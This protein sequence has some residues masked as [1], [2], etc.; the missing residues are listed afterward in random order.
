MSKDYYEILGVDEEATTEQIKRAYRRK[1]MKVHPDVAQGEDAAEKFKELSEAYEVLSDS[2][3]RAIYD[4]GGDPL[5]R[6]G[7]G[8]AG[9]FGGTGFGGFDFSTIMD[10]MFG[11]QGAGG[12]GG[13]LVWVVFIP[14]P[15]C[16]PCWVVGGPPPARDPVLS[17][18]RMRWS[19]QGW[20][21]MR[22]FLDA[23]NPSGSTRQWCARGARA[24]AGRPGLSR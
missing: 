12:A 24:Q 22:L 23:R 6:G 14:P 18:G 2:N 16:R 11:G 19:G 15:F 7:A 21:C 17:G 9:G 4:Q 5:G 3:K 13:G 20:N 1:A 10:A 8:G